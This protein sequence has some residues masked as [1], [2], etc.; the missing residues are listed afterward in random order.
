MVRRSRTVNPPHGDLVVSVVCASPKLDILG[1]KFDSKHT[2]KDHLHG[3]VSHVTQ[4]I[5]I[6][7]SVKCVFVDICV[8]SLL[9][10]ICSPNPWDCSPVCGSPAECHLQLLERPVYSVVR[11]CHDQC[12]L[13]LCHR[14]HVA[15][16]SMLH[17][18][19]WN[20]NHS[21]FSELPSALQSLT[22][23]SYG[24]SSSIGVWSIKV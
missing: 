16:L 4:R 10:C 11:H 5:G 6:L 24:R 19:N 17:K 8:T 15:A 20:S 2:L 7:R 3:I 1:V 14:H 21:L 22:Y 12:F 9:L 18:V 23:S 13:W